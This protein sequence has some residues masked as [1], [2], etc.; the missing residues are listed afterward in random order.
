MESILWTSCKHD[1]E[2]IINLNIPLREDSLP[3]FFNNESCNDFEGMIS[4]HDE[5]DSRKGKRSFIQRDDDSHQMTRLIK[6]LS[7]I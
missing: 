3:K 5:K 1:D 2:P 4:V 6:Q 7:S